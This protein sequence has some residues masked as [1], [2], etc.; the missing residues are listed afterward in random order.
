[1]LI[2]VLKAHFESMKGKSN[3]YWAPI[4]LSELTEDIVLN[5]FAWYDKVASIPESTLAENVY[6]IFELRACVR[7]FYL[8]LCCLLFFSPSPHFNS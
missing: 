7:R 1:V 6:L 4:A 2:D 8:S 5:G 3:V